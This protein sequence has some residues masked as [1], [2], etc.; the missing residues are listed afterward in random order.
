FDLRP[1]PRR[2]HRRG[3]LFSSRRRLRGC[4]F[5]LAPPCRSGLARDQHLG[6]DL[7]ESRSLPCLHGVVEGRPR[8]VVTLAKLK[9]RVG[10]FVVHV[11][12]SQ[13]W[14]SLTAHLVGPR[15]ATK[16]KEKIGV[17]YRI[18]ATLFGLKPSLN[19]DSS[20]SFW[21]AAATNFP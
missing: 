4:G 19:A 1:A 6:P 13:T 3:V 12:P 8:K 20:T 5:A 16:R 10:V 21:R 14:D 7:N 9:D 15:I 2:R 18:A 17:P 11:R